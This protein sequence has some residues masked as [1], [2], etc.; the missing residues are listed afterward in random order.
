MKVHLAL[1]YQCVYASN[2]VRDIDFSVSQSAHVVLNRLVE[3]NPFYRVWNAIKH[4]NRLDIADIYRLRF[5]G[6]DIRRAVHNSVAYAKKK[7]TW[8]SESPLWQY[9]EEELEDMQDNEKDEIIQLLRLSEIFETGGANN[10]AIIFASL[11]SAL[12][13]ALVAFMIASSSNGEAA[14]E[15]DI[16]RPPSGSVP[17]DLDSGAATQ[18]PDTF[19]TDTP[20]RGSGGR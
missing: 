19:A 12:V 4:S 18:Q 8:I 1:F 14:V 10:A 7:E 3:R 13:A 6:D 2:A 20:P 9:V 16:T 11:L 5:A 17:S 15:P